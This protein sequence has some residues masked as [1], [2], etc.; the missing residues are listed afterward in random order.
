MRRILRN[1][2][3]QI[4]LALAI[5]MSIV[6]L[7]VSFSV[8]QMN[9]GRRLLKYEPAKEV[10]LAVTSDFERALAVALRD[11]SLK[12]N[13]T[14][15]NDAVNAENAANIVGGNA[16]LKWMRS[17]VTAYSHLGAEMEIRDKK[18]E[19]IGYWNGTMGI[20]SA[21]AGFSM[22]VE[23]YGF[24]GWIGKSEKMVMLTIFPDT[25][26]KANNS[27][28]L[29]FSMLDNGKPVPNLTPSLLKV[30]AWNE[31][32][33]KWDPA[34]SINIEYLGG[35]Y[36]L[37]SFSPIDEDRFGVKLRAITPKDRIIVS[38]RYIEGIRSQEDWG[39]LYL[40]VTED[41][42]NYEQLL[43]NHL[44]WWNPGPRQVTW[45]ISKAHP[46]REVSSPTI[47]E[48]RVINTSNNINITLYVQPS[49]PN[50]P[51]TIN[52]KVY[53]KYGVT[54]YPVAEVNGYRID[55]GEGYYI[56]ITPNLYKDVN[57][58]AGFGVIP[59]GSIVYLRVELVDLWA[60]LHIIYR[61]SK[62]IL[63]DPPQT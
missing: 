41:E 7:S 12:F 26:N 19:F 35:G 43:P 29:V 52:I 18:F 3:G 33:S 50:K 5:I 24:K 62:I 8:Y 48:G 23:A 38:A 6:V 59:S 53:F 58:G 17:A 21:S 42:R 16:L 2:R 51:V 14:Y 39:T 31:S 46:T 49:P 28:T 55:K 30:Y 40:G 27:A 34:A 37:L 44:L 54:E 32:L 10:V 45:V 13:E 20:S 1:N 4:I 9:A 56:I 25:I 63:S 60:T 22:D 57:A 15:E 61:E 36:Y 47:P 11:A